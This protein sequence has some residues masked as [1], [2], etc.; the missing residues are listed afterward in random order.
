MR[1]NAELLL[2]HG[3]RPIAEYRD[4]V[5]DIVDESDRLGRLVADLL[6]LARADEGR[7]SLARTEVDLSALGA[8]A[9]RPGRGR[10]KRRPRR[11]LCRR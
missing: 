7:L 9:R 1:G 10:E 5:Q 4:V 8:G 11:T 2:R 3:D 6:T